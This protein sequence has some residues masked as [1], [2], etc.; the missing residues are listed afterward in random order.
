[1]TWPRLDGLFDT[2]PINLITDSDLSSGVVEHEH[3]HAISFHVEPQ[4]HNPCLMH[5]G[6]LEALVF[7]TV[8]RR[9]VV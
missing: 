3:E 9:R 6:L 1:M 2:R 8:E 4:N 7:V 5:A